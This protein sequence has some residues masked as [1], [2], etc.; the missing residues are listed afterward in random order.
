MKEKKIFKLFYFVFLFVL[1]T[2]FLYG[3]FLYFGKV[4]TDYGLRASSWQK[5]AQHSHLIA[6]FLGTFIL[7]IL[8]Q[9]HILPRLSSP[10]KRNSGILLLSLAVLMLLSGYLIQI[11]TEILYREMMGISHS[12]F[13]LLFI[14]SFLFHLRKSSDRKTQF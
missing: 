13:S 7:G 3:Y 9:G 1:L 12:I 10:K 8:F 2:G 14:V 6:A 5:L 4:Q 11:Q